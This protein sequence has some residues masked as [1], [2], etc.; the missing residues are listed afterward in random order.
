VVGG[1]TQ[2][3]G[4]NRS[5]DA[6][7]ADPP[8]P[9]A[10]ANT[11]VAALELTDEDVTTKGVRER[12]FVVGRGNVDV[13]GLLWTPADAEGARPL[14]LIGHGAAGSKRDAH[15]VSLARQLVRHRSFAAAAIDGPVHGDRR[16]DG[17]AD[18]ALVLAEFAQRWANDPQMVDQMVA[19][20]RATLDALGALEEVGTEAVGWWGLSMGTIFGVPVVAAEPRI[21]AAVLGLMGTGGPSEQ[22]RARMLADAGAVRCP[23]LFLLQWDDEIMK[24]EHVLALFGAIASLDK[25]LHA[26]PGR[27]VEVPVE[28]LDASEQFLAHHLGS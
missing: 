20:W 3:T 4:S 13:P 11:P 16:A 14:V 10:R 8:A 19:D 12:G 27:H 25:R 2:L 28:E 24:R 9:R 22:A 1:T 21:G 23:V 15:V 26:H 17:G 5:T 7:A 18:S 6:Q